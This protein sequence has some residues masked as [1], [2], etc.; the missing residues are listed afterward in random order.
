[1][2]LAGFFPKHQTLMR[3]SRLVKIF[4]LRRNLAAATIEQRNLGLTTRIQ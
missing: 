4:L 3:A 2:I 1:M